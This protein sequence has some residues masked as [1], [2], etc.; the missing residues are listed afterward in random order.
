VR[1]SI[2]SNT[3]KIEVM[4]FWFMKKSSVFPDKSTKKE[5]EK[6]SA[7]SNLS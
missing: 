7:S 2:N 1:G 3:I 5:A 6:N 4:L